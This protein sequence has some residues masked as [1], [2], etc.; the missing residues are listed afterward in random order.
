MFKKLLLTSLFLINLTSYAQNSVLV[1]PLELKNNRNV[2][3]TVNAEKKEVTL[4]IS[5][6]EK[7]KAFLAS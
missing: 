2:F 3:Q 1:T 7:I 6:K 4:F 5:D